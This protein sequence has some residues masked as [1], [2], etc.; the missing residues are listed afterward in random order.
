M[1]DQGP[2]KEREAQASAGPPGPMTDLAFNVL[3]ALEG[4]PLHGYALIKQLRRRT[5]RT[6]LRTGT[7]YAALARLTSDGWVREVEPPSGGGDED[8]RRRYYALTDTGRI[9][10][11]AEAARLAEVLALAR[12]K[13]LTPEGVRS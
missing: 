4:Q 5:G 9:A 10:A 7:V 13:G 12:R 1:G 8:G 3:V 11:A 2:E 6:G